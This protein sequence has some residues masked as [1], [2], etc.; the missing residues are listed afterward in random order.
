[1][2]RI[3]LGALVLALGLLLYVVVDLLPLVGW[4]MDGQRAFH[5]ALAQNLNSLA[6]EASGAAAWGLAVMSFLYGIF[7]AAGPGHGKAVVAAYLFT[8]ES[9]LKRGL[10]LAAASSL[11]QGMVAVAVVYGLIY[12]AGWVPRET[13]AA[14]A[15]T[16]RL[17]FL[18]LAAMGLVLMAGAVRR[19]TAERRKPVLSIGG[20]VCCTGVVPSAAALDKA[21]GW[22]GMAGLVLSVGLRPCSG[23][24]LVLALAKSLGLPWAGVAAVGAMA[25]GTALTVAALAVL[26]VKARGWTLSMFLGDGGR[27]RLAADGLGLAGGGIIA[28]LALSLLAGSFAPAHPLGL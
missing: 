25:G 2:R 18:L 9:K 1:M 23:A 12:L 28:A 19:L 27:V 7:H 26:T 5:R 20:D 15:W 6:G 21:K 3:G 14:V 24:V 8:H 13:K 16:E 4:I 17:S 10:A 22:R 11:V